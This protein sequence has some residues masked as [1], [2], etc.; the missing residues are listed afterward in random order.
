MARLVA[1]AVAM[2]RRRELASVA[3]PELDDEAARYK[4]QYIS[5]AIQI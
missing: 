1:A 5:S 2:F 3:C 4:N